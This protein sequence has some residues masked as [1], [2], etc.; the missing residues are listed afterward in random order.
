V[1]GSAIAA[2]AMDHRAFA[3]KVG[4]T[5]ERQNISSERFP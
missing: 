4:G 2:P 3:A 5:Q 1:T